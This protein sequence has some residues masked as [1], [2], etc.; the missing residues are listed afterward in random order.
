[1]EAEN[2]PCCSTVAPKTLMALPDNEFMSKDR[3]AGDDVHTVEMYLDRVVWNARNTEKSAVR[4][5]HAHR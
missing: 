5:G 3:Q 4:L 1:M 2:G